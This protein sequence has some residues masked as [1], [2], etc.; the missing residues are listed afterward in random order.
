MLLAAPCHQLP[1]HPTSQLS[2]LF[3]CLFVCFLF[4]CLQ[5]CAWEKE[6]I[7]STRQVHKAFLLLSMPCKHRQENRQ[8]DRFCF[9]KLL[10]HIT[11]I[12]KATGKKAKNFALSQSLIAWGGFFHAVLI[13]LQQQQT[14]GRPGTPP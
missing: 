4:V 11:P 9:F 2:F 6:Q 14:R 3:F 13:L 1:Q 8:D 12:W 7:C 10:L 5:L